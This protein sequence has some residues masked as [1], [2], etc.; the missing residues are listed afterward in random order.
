MAGSVDT[1]CWVL[2]VDCNWPTPSFYLCN[3]G[4]SVSRPNNLLDQVVR[5]VFLKQ[6]YDCKLIQEK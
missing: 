1:Y 2:V 3:Q 4:L 6:Y 5:F